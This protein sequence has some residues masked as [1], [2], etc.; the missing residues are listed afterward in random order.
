MIFKKGQSFIEIAISHDLNFR[1]ER[2]PTSHPC[3]V[4]ATIFQRIN[5]F[6]VRLDNISS[7]FHIFNPSAERSCNIGNKMSNIFLWPRVW[8]FLY[9]SEQLHLVIMSSSALCLFVSTK[10][11]RVDRNTTIYKKYVNPQKASWKDYKCQLLMSA[12][13]NE[14]KN[15]KKH[16]I[17]SHLGLIQ[18]HLKP[19]INTPC[20]VHG[21][22]CGF[23]IVDLQKYH[24]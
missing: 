21:I 13:E 10:L 6:L 19:S 16:G 15:L 22:S 4:W 18:V 8:L 9:W 11:L 2:N 5:F 3:F 20:N 17:K 1:C 23:L 7:H 14:I 12:T 24:Y